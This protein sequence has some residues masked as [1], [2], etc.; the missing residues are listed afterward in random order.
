MLTSVHIKNFRSC[1]DVK[2]EGMGPMLGL[3]GRNGAGKTTILRAIERAI[4]IAVSRDFREVHDVNGGL[5]SDGGHIVIELCIAGREYIYSVDTPATGLKEDLVVIDD[6]GTRTSIFARNDRS[7]VLGPGG[8][9]LE[10]G[11]HAASMPAMATLL[12]EDDSVQAQI[13][14]V[15]T[16]FQAVRYYPG[17]GVEGPLGPSSEEPY[18]PIAAVVYE[19]WAARR[20]SSVLIR[21]LHAHFHATESLDELRRLLGREGLG[22]IDDIRIDVL[23]TGARRGSRQYYQV[24]FKTIDGDE[25]LSLRQLSG[26]TL[27]VLYL[28][29]GLLFDRSSVMLIEQP[30][31]GIHPGLLAKLVDLLRVN[32]DPTQ[33]I[34]ASHSPT[35]L[36]SLRPTDVRLVEMRDGATG[37]RA[38]TEVEVRRAQDYMQREGSLAEF[39]ELIQ[40]D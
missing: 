13:D 23:D 33:I 16:M 22:L 18:E 39:L 29:V 19:G 37:V 28:L 26:G 8:R 21:L 30:E 14:P 6:Q 15:I 3:V 1:K 40:E 11:D 38:L 12:A 36:S 2:L 10:I 7:L 17:F 32:V 5:T 31:D 4:A 24:M 25:D 9:H 34:L 27:Q 35:V 20:T